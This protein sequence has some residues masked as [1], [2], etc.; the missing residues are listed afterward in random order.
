M[1]RSRGFEI[2]KI[3]F[4]PHRSLAT[5]RGAF[6]GIELDVSG[7]GDHLDRFDFKIK[8][9]KEMMR[10]MAMGQPY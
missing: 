5:H 1:L 4:D 2:K 10:M 6:P 3:Y 8:R 9:I 7:A